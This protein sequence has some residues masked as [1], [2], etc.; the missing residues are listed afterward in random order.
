MSHPM[1]DILYDELQIMVNELSKCAGQIVTFVERE[2]IF[3]DFSKS[4]MYHSIRRIAEEQHNVWERI[5]QEKENA[6]NN[7][8]STR[9][10]GV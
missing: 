9:N 3:E 4:G 5:N 1:N 7:D 2:G 8:N 6:R 10:T